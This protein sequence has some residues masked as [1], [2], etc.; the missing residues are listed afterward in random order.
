MRFH[1]IEGSRENENVKA[2]RPERG[3]GA[4]YVKRQPPEAPS[5]FT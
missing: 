5:V 3:H 4:A 1:A 2:S